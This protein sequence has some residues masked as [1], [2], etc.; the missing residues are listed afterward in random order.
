MSH[1]PNKNIY[2]FQA[3]SNDVQEIHLPEYTIGC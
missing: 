3:V 1:E 2:T